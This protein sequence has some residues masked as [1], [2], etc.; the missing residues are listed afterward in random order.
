VSERCLAADIR[1]LAEFNR[2]AAEVVAR[3]YEEAGQ[4]RE[5]VATI[6]TACHRLRQDLARME[7][8]IQAGGPVAGVL[9]QLRDE[10]AGLLPEGFVALY[11]DQRLERIPVYLEAARLRAGRAVENFPRHRL[12]EE[13]AAW[14]RAELERLVGALG[15]E[16]TPAKRAAVEEFFWL[17]EE[18]KI[19]VF[20][21]EI[22]TAGPVSAKR[23]R[24]QIRRIDTMI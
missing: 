24:Q 7:E 21:Q 10:L 2:L 18:Y 22:K 19:S 17:V 4:L 16:S 23:L 9:Q 6:L 14:A 15:P 3:L 5:R 1:R 12:K 20:A 13:Q 11:E 8:K